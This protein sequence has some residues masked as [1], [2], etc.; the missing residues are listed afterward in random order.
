MATARLYLLS[1]TS[2]RSNSDTYL[3]TF[4]QSF[5]RQIIIANVNSIYIKEDRE[6]RL[7]TF[8]KIFDQFGKQ[9]ISILN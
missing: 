7:R 8:S 5:L 9:I 6:A 2:Y 3:Y 4:L 1:T